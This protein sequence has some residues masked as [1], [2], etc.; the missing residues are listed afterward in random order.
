MNS[1]LSIARF[2][3][4]CR[5]NDVRYILNQKTEE[6]VREDVFKR[7]A[8]AETAARKAGKNKTPTLSALVE[9]EAG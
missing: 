6:L 7:E 1:H 5:I 3:G 4:G 9:R 2:S 8:K